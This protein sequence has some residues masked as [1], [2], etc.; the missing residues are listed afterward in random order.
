M[1]MYKINSNQPFQA[2]SRSFHAASYFSF[3]NL[4]H[5]KKGHVTSEDPP[6]LLTKPPN[7]LRIP[8]MSKSSDTSHKT[9]HY[10]AVKFA[11]G[12][13]IYCELK[14]LV[15]FHE[16]DL[17]KKLEKGWCAMC[18]LKP[19]EKK[20]EGKLIGA[21]EWDGERFKSN[22]KE[23][24]HSV[25]FLQ[26]KLHHHGENEEVV[27]REAEE[28]RQLVQQRLELEKAAGKKVNFLEWALLCGLLVIM[29]VFIRYVFLYNH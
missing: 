3:T 16:D 28:L 12:K 24:L 6:L 7:M 19:V 20:S 26:P 10:L 23:H 9:S 1:L 5:S 17:S 14:P 13:V 22:L 25:K 15:N 18:D 11:G 2:L 29:G 8:C 27:D 21:V 4:A